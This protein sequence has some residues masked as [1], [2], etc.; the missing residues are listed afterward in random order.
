MGL[1]RELCI[2]DLC[3]MRGDSLRDKLRLRHQP[4]LRLR[5][6]AWILGRSLSSPLM[7]SADFSRPRPPLRGASAALGKVRSVRPFFEDVDFREFRLT[8]PA[9]CQMSLV[10]ADDER[11]TAIPLPARVL[12][13]GLSRVG[14][15][16]RP[17]PPAASAPLQHDRT[18]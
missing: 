18:P 12:S 9:T 2:L 4:A 3:P 15:T 17:F 1:S 14:R 10:P 6:S 5:S 16:N 7:L 8:G 13:S 11:T